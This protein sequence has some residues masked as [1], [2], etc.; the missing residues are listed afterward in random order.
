MQIYTTSRFFMNY[1]VVQ[2]NYIFEMIGYY[3]NP[4]KKQFTVKTH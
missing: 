3:E 2:V 4:K 1:S